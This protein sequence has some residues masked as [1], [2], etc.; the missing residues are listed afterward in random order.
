M[1]VYCDSTLNP[2]VCV[3]CAQS[4]LSLFDPMDSRPPGFSVH[5]IFQA[6]RWV[7]CYFVFQ[8]I[9]LTQDWIHVCCIGRLILY[10]RGAQTLIRCGH[11]NKRHSLWF[12]SQFCSSRV[13]LFFFL[14][15]HW[16]SKYTFITP[17][18]MA[19]HFAAVAGVMRSWLLLCRGRSRWNFLFAGSPLPVPLGQGFCLL[20]LVMCWVVEFLFP[21]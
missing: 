1:R 20:M 21:I 11:C 14:Y 5:E 12:S 15:V 7:D 2:K 9:S 6:R 19:R 3:L 18:L 13:T 16:F 8:S 17:L 10:H 4:C